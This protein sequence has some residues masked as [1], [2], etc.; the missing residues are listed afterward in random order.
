MASSQFEGTR[1]LF[2]LPADEMIYESV[3]CASGESLGYKGRLY[4]SENFLSFS[5]NM[6]GMSKKFSIRIQEISDIRLITAGTLKITT[7]N[8]K[9]QVIGGFGKYKDKVMKLISSLYQKEFGQDD[10]DLDDEEKVNKS[11]SMSAAPK[12]SALMVIFG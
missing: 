1:E 7:S 6:I 3:E 12:E 9:F 2:N 10:S 4:I 5:C 11:L 8:G